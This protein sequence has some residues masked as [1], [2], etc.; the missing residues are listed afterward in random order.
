MDSNANPEGQLMA[1]QQYFLM[2]Q[3]NLEDGKS[4]Q[5]M[6]KT[7]LD[8]EYEAYK[9]DLQLKFDFDP[10]LDAEN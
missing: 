7:A 10:S 2:R 4:K 1:N 9:N 6:V 3:K 5:K 8:A